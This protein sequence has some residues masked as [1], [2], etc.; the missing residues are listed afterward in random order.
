MAVIGVGDIREAEYADELL[1][2]ERLDLVAIGRAL[3]ADPAWAQ[4]AAEKLGVK[5]QR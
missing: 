3:L 1:R 2:E 5:V 4:K